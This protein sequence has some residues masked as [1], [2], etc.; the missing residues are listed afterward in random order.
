MHYRAF[1]TFGGFTSGIGIRYANSAI[2][3]SVNQQIASALTIGKRIPPQIIIRVADARPFEIQDL[4]PA[5]TKFRILLFVGNVTDSDQAQRVHKLA[6]DMGK[7]EGFLNKFGR[8]RINK[9]GDWDVFDLVTICAGR[10][11]N[12]SY[13]D[14][15]K[16]F[17]THWTK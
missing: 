12:V 6:T 9:D 11:E 2:T 1:Q 5:D 17:R 10:K 15:P 4:C 14:V 7:P 8:S 3:S 16:F 13:L